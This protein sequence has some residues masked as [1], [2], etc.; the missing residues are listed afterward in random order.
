MI[1]TIKTNRNNRQSRKLITLGELAEAMRHD[2]PNGDIETLRFALKDQLRSNGDDSDLEYEA[3]GRLPIV[4][5]AAELNIDGD[6]NKQVRVYNGLLTLTAGPLHD[7]DEAERVKSLAAVLPTTVA[8]VRGCGGHSVKIIVRA[9]R[10]DFN[11]AACNK[12]P[13]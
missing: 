6:G 8:A 2:T 4:Y 11:F 7:E 9:T 3:I 13:K 12:S 1:T 5:P 10:P